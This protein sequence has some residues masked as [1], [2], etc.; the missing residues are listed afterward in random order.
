LLLNNL[1]ESLGQI[2]LKVAI[3]KRRRGIPKIRILNCRP[4]GSRHAVPRNQRLLTT[5]R[6]RSNELVV[7]RK[8]GNVSNLRAGAA[9]WRA[10]VLLVVTMGG[11]GDAAESGSGRGR[12]QPDD[13]VFPVVAV[14]EALR[15]RVLGH[16]P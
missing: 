1:D 12:R 14:T 9:E 13:N 2:A 15:G 10:R 3:P 8:V 16:V 4:R 5:L 6:I 11:D 7:E